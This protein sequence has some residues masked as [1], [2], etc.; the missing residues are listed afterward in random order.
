MK[1]DDRDET[2][3]IVLSWSFIVRQCYNNGNKAGIT[4]TAGK[5]MVFCLAKK[6]GKTACKST[7][8]NGFIIRS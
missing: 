5:R 6:T 8:D 1:G 7:A 4:T 3:A 2:Y